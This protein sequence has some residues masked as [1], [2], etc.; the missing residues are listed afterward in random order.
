[1]I[2]VAIFIRNVSEGDNF[3]KF[4]ASTGLKYSRSILVISM[5]A[6]LDE[7]HLLQLWVSTTPSGKISFRGFYVFTEYSAICSFNPLF[8]DIAYDI[9]KFRIDLAICLLFRGFWQLCLRFFT[10]I[11]F[12]Y[13]NTHVCHYL[14]CV[15][16][17]RFRFRQ[18]Y[19][20]QAEWVSLST[21]R[22]SLSKMKRSSRAIRSVDI[23]VL[24]LL[25]WNYMKLIGYLKNSCLSFWVADWEGSW[26][27]REHWQQTLFSKRTS[28]FYWFL[29]R[30]LF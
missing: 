17:K 15:R 10:F 19:M 14:C 2:W 25:L 29:V 20:L 9:I 27:G 24:I 12:M 30:S 6:K 7:E 21:N 16:P 8:I 28:Y 3:S 11:G 22:L 23:H 13:D 4:Y 5:P 18:W 26:N 1:M